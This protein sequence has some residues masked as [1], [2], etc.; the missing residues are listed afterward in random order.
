M[1]SVDAARMR[2][3]FLKLFPQIIHRHHQIGS[4]D[5]VRQFANQITPEDGGEF[6]SGIHVN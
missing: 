1:N 3:K 6:V 4:V 5:E 2:Q